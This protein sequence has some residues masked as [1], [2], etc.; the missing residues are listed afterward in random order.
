MGR[1]GSVLGRVLVR[2][3]LRASPWD[4]GLWPRLAA[5]A[6]NSPEITVRSGSVRQFSS[7]DDHRG[8]S[9]QL[10][11]SHALEHVRRPIRSEK[12]DAHAFEGRITRVVGCYI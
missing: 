4:N 3:A 6:F 10:S 8:M 9:R 1:H 2:Y 5:W 11:G 7:L 12:D